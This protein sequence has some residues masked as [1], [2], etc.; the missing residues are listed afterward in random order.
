MKAFQKNILRQSSKGRI[1]GD[2]SSR[3]NRSCKFWGSPTLTYRVK[4]VSLTIVFICTL[5]SCS[6]VHGEEPGNFSAP[7]FDLNSAPKFTNES[8]VR[9]IILTIM[10]VISFFGNAATVVSIKRQ[11]QSRSTVHKLILHMAI[12]DLLVTFACMCMEAVW[13]YT[14]KWLAG[15]FVCKVMKY[16]QVCLSHYICS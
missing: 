6:G 8:L 9:A 7:N 2:F 16:L 11:K 12:A 1:M 3:S 13:M 4:F 10:A 14:V 15:N 5:C